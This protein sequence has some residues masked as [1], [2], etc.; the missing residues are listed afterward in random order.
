M[1]E[2]SS[3][4]AFATVASQGVKKEVGKLDTLYPVM[5]RRTG[6]SLVRAPNI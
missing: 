3:E 5:D 4:R 2:E 6:S 1:Q